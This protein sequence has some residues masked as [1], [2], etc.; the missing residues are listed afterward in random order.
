MATTATTPSAPKGS[1][2]RAQLNKLGG[3]IVEALTAIEFLALQLID[4]SKAIEYE[5]KKYTSRDLSEQF[6]ALRVA[7]PKELSTVKKPT[8]ASNADPAKPVTRQGFQQVN[9]FKPVLLTFLR[10]PN[11]RISPP[12]FHPFVMDVDPATGQVFR[13]LLPANTAVNDTINF[14][15]GP[16]VTIDGKTYAREGL[17]DIQTLRRIFILYLQQR[18]LLGVQVQDKKGK[19]VLNKSFF[20]LDSLL[21]QYFGAEFKEIENKINASHQANPEKTPPFNP[22]CIPTCQ[23]V[24]ILFK[25][26]EA[27]QPPKDI[28][29]NPH[30]IGGLISDAEILEAAVR[31]YDAPSSKA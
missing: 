1:G 25:L 19:T 30:M 12:N 5:G 22:N 27:T 15:R 6:K 13:K 7:I 8:K 23:L 28:L 10:D 14:N 2:K 16:P 26:R 11:A 31:S 20:K 21:L 4:P 17:S 24:S 29:Q 3:T 18:G 9:Y